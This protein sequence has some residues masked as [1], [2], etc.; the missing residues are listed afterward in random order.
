VDTVAAGANELAAI[1]DE[2]QG[3]AAARHIRMRVSGCGAGT[4]ASLCDERIGLVEVVEDHDIA[5][6]SG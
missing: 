5:V 3:A 6:S 1:D 2:P 4:D